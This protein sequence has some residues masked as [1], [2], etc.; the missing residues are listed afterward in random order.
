VTSSDMLK[1]LQNHLEYVIKYKEED[2]AKFHPNDIRATE[3][4]DEGEAGSRVT[5]IQFLTANIKELKS[6]L[7]AVI[8]ISKNQSKA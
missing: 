4:L 3:Y 5:S 6:I 2:L 7:N 1:V 8:N